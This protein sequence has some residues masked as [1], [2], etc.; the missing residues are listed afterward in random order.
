MQ[1]VMFTIKEKYY[2][3]ESK[4]VEE[5]TQRVTWT[6]VPTAPKWVQGLINLRGEVLTLINFQ[7]LLYPDG[8]D[9]DLC[10]NRTIILSTEKGKIALMVDSV[11]EVTTIDPAD[12]ELADNSSQ[13]K[14]SG[15]VSIKD[16]I[17][18]VLNL[19]ALLPKSEGE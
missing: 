2:V 12:I 6:H 7:Q 11:E 13:G 16:K 9:G 1:I 3:I 19:D 10:Y 4:N 14:V 15:V 17:V 18:S 5:I 8:G